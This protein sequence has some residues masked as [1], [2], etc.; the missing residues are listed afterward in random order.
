LPIARTITMTRIATA[1]GVDKR[2]ERSWIKGLQDAFASAGQEEKESQGSM[3]M[4]K[5]GDVISCPIWAGKP[6]SEEAEDDSSSDSDDEGDNWARQ[7]AKKPTALA[8]FLVTGLSYEPLNAVEEDFRSS[9]SSKARAGEL[10][11]WVDAQAN[12]STRMVLTGVERSRVVR[13]R[14]EKIWRGIG[15]LRAQ[16]FPKKQD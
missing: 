7:S 8:Y 11:C 13:R 2:Y 9:I 4:V 15:E 6:L 16:L 14:D 12:G 5:R 3:R 10:G 1:E